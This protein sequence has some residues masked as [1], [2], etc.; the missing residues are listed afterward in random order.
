MRQVIFLLPVTIR[1]RLSRTLPQWFRS[2]PLVGVCM[3]CLAVATVG[4]R[5]GA[6]ST[7]EPV[8]PDGAVLDSPLKVAE[9]LR[10]WHQDRRYRLFEGWVLPDHRVFLVD[11]LMA[12]GRLLDANARAQEVLA[13][14][15]GEL[16]AAEYNLGAL[17]NC[18]GFF[19][20]DAVFR[21]E[22]ID[23]DQAVVIVQ[24]AD[25]VPMEEYRF[26]R[27][28]GRWVY[29]PT[30][31]LALLPRLVV[32]LTEG[33]DQ[34]IDAVRRE[35]MDL[36]DVKLAFSRHVGRRQEA[37]RRTL[38]TSSGHEPAVSQPSPTSSMY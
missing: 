2:R 3:L 7:S 32:E 23:G 9:A 25:Q 33:V 8:G 5:E 15:H 36:K 38:S 20:R 34:F 31:P 16:T 18:L 27:Q 24:V 13:A 22:R 4:C 26:V 29:A 10:S 37:I 21:G 12:F 6:D 28:Q 17:A 19:S 14:K 35:E 11:T 1:L 30:D